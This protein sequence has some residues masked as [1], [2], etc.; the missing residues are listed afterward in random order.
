MSDVLQDS[1]LQAMME[2]YEALYVK[3]ASS[4]ERLASMKRGI[5]DTVKAFGRSV[6]HG[7]VEATFRKG[8]ERTSWDS[9]GLDGYRVA[10]PEISA[11]RSTKQVGP[12]VAI[13]VKEQ[14]D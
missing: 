11:F 13:K 3:L 12:S 2:E 6:E 5:Q 9:K 14:K 1:K 10:H 8:Y 4:I 7:N